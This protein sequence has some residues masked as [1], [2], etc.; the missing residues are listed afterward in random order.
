MIAVMQRCGL[1]GDSGGEHIVFA[2]GPFL[3]LV[4][5]AWTGSTR[6]PRHAALIEAAT[7]L[8][9]RVHGHPATR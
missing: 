1:A 8:Y 9:Q 4:G 5:N 3:Y 2:D 7:K 6:N